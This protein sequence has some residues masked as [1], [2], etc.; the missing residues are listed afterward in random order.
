[1][2]KVDG[3]DMP[4]PGQDGDKDTDCAVNVERIFWIFNRQALGDSH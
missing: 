2:N 3:T 4:D 1:V